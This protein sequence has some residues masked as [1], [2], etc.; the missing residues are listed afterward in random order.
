MKTRA[1]FT[2]VVVL[3]FIVEVVGA[4][5]PRS[6]ASRSRVAQDATVPATVSDH[7]PFKPLAGR[8]STLLPN[9]KLLMLG[10]EDDKGSVATAVI[11]DPS[12][13]SAT[14]LSNHLAQARAWHTATVLPDGTVL[15][16]G[17]VGNE[18]ELVDSV[19]VFDPE[20]QKFRVV[21]STDFTPRAHHSA[22]LLTDGRL[23]IAG[24]VSTAGEMLGTTQLWDPKMQVAV[25][26]AAELHIPRQDH[27]A[28]LLPD[29]TVLLWGGK[30]STGEPLK[31]GE[32]FD[33]QSESFSPIETLP[34]LA[35]APGETARLAGSI[36]ANGDQDVPTDGIIAL[37]F[38]KPLQANTVTSKTVILTGPEGAV[39]VSVVPAEGG[40]LV[41]V[42]PKQPLTP[43][44]NYI[45]RL[46]GPRDTNKRPVP[47]LE[48]SF[49]TGTTQAIGQ[50]PI[51]G[52]ESSSANA[53]VDSPW[54]KLP[55][56]RASA[57]VTAIAG[58]VLKLNGQP[59]PNVTLMLGMDRSIMT[60]TDRTGRFLLPLPSLATGHYQFT[61]DGASASAPGK[62]YGMFCVR[63][64]ITA[65]T[66]NVLP[67]TIWMPVID[68]HHSISL[69]VPTTT[70]IVATTP[71]IPGLELHIPPGIVIRE[72]DGSLATSL[73]ITPV[74]MTRPPFPLPPGLKAPVYFTTQPGASMVESSGAEAR[75]IRIVFP[76]RSGWPAGLRV[77]FWS[78]DPQ[79]VGW[80][81]YGQG[82][83]TADGKQVVPDAGVA[84]H[85]LTCGF[86]GPGPGAPPSTW[87]VNDATDG[88]P[89]DLSTGLFVYRKTDFYLP[90]VIPIV[91]TRV[92]RPGDNSTPPRSF[93]I[94]TS[95]SY[96]MFLYFGDTGGTDLI[97][98]DGQRIFYPSGGPTPKV[99]TA[100]PTI[101]YG[102]IYASSTVGVNYYNTITLKDG[103]VYYF[104]TQATDVN[105][106]Y[107][108]HSFLAAI[109][110]RHGNQ[111]T[112]T[113]QDANDQN[114]T[115]IQ[116]PNGRS[117]QFT[118]DG[119]SR[120]TQIQDNIG[121]TTSYTYDSSGRL[122]TATDANGGVTTFTYDSL[123]E[124]LTVKDPRLITYL[125]NAYDSNGRVTKQTLADSSTYQYA[126]TL[127]GSSVT[128]TKVTDPLGIVR[129]VTF[130]SS[131]YTLTD[132]YAVGKPEQQA[133]TYTRDATSNFVLTATDALGRETTY[134]YDSKGNMTTVIQLAGTSN[135]VT[136]SFTYEPTFS[137]LASVTDPLNHTTN[138]SY[139]ATDNLTALTD[140]LQH[141]WT[142]TYNGAGQPLTAADPL[143]NTTQFTYSGGDLVG[144]TDPN[145]NAVSRFLD[146][147]GRLISVAD[148]LGNATQY[149][150]DAL[151]QIVQVTDPL[152]GLTKFAYDGNGNPSSVTDAR[153]NVTSYTYD[154][155][156]RLASRKDPLSRSETY[157]YDANGNM[158]QFTDRR[159]KVAVFTYDNLNRLTFA[160][161]GKTVV[162]KVTNY[163]S[164]V[165]YTYD[166]GNRL[167]QLVDSQAGTI[168]RGYDGLDRLTSEGTPQGSVSYSYDNAGRR[169]G[170]TVAGQPNVS[171]AYDNA[172][173]L[174]G[175][176]QGSSTVTL[177]YDTTG[178][179]T[180]LTL[181]NGVQTAYS[182]DAASQLTGLTYTVG[183][184]TMGNLT[185]SND[186]AGRRT[187]VGGSFARTG[188]PLAVAS[189]TY[190]AANELTK[191]G[192]ASPTYDAN[193]NLTNDGLN[194]YAWDARNQLKS[195]VAGGTTIGSFQYDALGRRW[196]KAVAGTTTLFLYDDANAVQELS[197]GTPPAPTANVVAGS[198]VDE[199]FS[200][201]DSAGARYFLTDALGSTLALSDSTG[202]LQTQ[203]TYDP[204][205]NTSFSGPASN[206]SY[207]YTGRENDGTGLYFYRARYYGLTTGRFVSEDP[208]RFE[209][210]VNFYR[211]VRN[212]PT[213]WTDPTGL[214]TLKNF[215][216]QGAAQMS[217]AIGK[218][219]AKLKHGCCADKRLRN[220]LLNILQPNN[221]G[222]GATFDYVNNLPTVENGF[223]T[224]AE[225]ADTFD[226]IFNTITI[227]EA[228]LNGTSPCPLEGIL[229]HELVHL[230]WSNYYSSVSAREAE[231]YAVSAA[232]FGSG[233][234]H[235]PNP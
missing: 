202:A 44:T 147:A 58:Q 106:P 209:Q 157:Q 18:G 29:G 34:A 43:S 126:Y 71:V 162:K 123:N 119:S 88:E 20:S 204:F 96:N 91:F 188:L 185:Y 152:N 132:T 134:A 31:N 133:Y 97:L 86:I 25:N 39:G 73:S 8:S 135:A 150:Y 1:R 144:I 56:L 169:A 30:A 131:G 64:D 112:I 226:F 151:N 53:S 65:G 227:A 26:S 122:A 170:M 218:L 232:C 224:V 115:S 203:Y 95:H 66:T 125:T 38:S 220:R 55:P 74:S 2:L 124:M 105:G 70:E 216:P 89:V 194:T 80:F 77:N 136:T 17:G 213:N 67:Y 186:N 61:M 22:T 206:N 114:I 215:T 127:S 121:R 172:D 51:P 15:V 94:G 176:T 198:G 6:T 120:I 182:Y 37:R 21:S 140:P 196:S 47:P 52:Q 24:G 155:R 142:F 98:P 117:L 208:I 235:P 40:L 199:T 111:L 54:Q 201:T 103:T 158:T 168:T 175:M 13:G 68:T 11:V 210:G 82:T 179:R 76:N 9:G 90:D 219:S 79:G 42:N 100:T 163:E 207:Q 93:G 33:P 57:G 45:L 41:F 193:G 145:G 231:A 138:F 110:D 81:V 16:L 116:S 19:E 109:K 85:R 92:Y 146:A 49:I 7:A 137:Q 75:G 104:T 180:T 171:Y 141:Q 101:F 189:A 108:Y 72:M 69:P 195:M 181:P 12:T 160:G 36:P 191:W 139:D 83:V 167:T 165:N 153:N 149:S 217:I 233:C 99:H 228:A 211:Y 84:V 222:T 190:D 113:R 223:V 107:Q 28:N 48:I 154:N 183:T 234:L 87:P 230:T 5:L 130:N 197:P 14:P 184:T 221:Y 166:A 27:S 177:A 148:P 118:Y 46:L 159:G 164:T 63:V 229:L 173:R 156:D 102:S 214:Y 4:S 129:Q 60:M 10:G 78:Y 192:T 143:N 161:F 62:T 128:Q 32:L 200:R 35:T 212:S 50:E 59:L 205:G 174:T 225:V 3:A 187:S 178:R 23:L